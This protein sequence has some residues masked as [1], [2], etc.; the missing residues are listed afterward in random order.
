MNNLKHGLKIAAVSMMAA[1]VLGIT[2]ANADP[3]SQQ[4]NKNLWRN[5]TIGSGALAVNG[6]VRHNSTETI[7]G[8]AGA[9]Y[10]ANRYEQDRHHQSQAQQAARY[11][12]AHRSYYHHSS[13]YSYYSYGGHRY[14][15][16]RSTGQ[17]LRIG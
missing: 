8:A 17:R 9:A 13:R 2:V 10:S 16:N 15:Y 4:Q 7:I 14:R 3:N 5:L 11:R 12:A 1:L 6:L